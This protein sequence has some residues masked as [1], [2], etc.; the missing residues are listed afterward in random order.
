MYRDSQFCVRIPRP[1]VVMYS[2]QGGEKHTT[3]PVEH[4]MVFLS[5]LR[6]G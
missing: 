1:L 2:R 5:I 6:S 3:T 4:L